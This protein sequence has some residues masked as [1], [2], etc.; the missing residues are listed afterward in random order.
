MNE[1]EAQEITRMVES[2]WNC[3]F[4]MQGRTLWCRMLYAFDADLAT[5]AV[6]EMVKFPLQGGKW[7]P[8]PADLRQVIV[9]MKARLPKPKEIT[10]GK[11]G[12]APPE[13]VWVWSWAR[14]RRD[15]RDDRGFPQQD[16]YANPDSLMSMQD[17][18]ELHAEWVKVGSPR[19][20]HPMA[21]ALGWSK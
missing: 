7:K 5:Q 16:G 20:S 10:E 11:W 4:G 6:V 8:Q 13:W 3:D 19:S 17:Y 12:T 9:A 1:R 18:E 2:G 21:G 14:L 15:P